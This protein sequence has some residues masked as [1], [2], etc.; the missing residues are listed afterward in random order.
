MKNKNLIIISISCVALL[1]EAC[2][3]ANNKNSKTESQNSSRSVTETNSSERI[4]NLEEIKIGTQTWAIENLDVSNF[5]NGDAISEAK[6]DEEW[7]KAGNEG[8][9]AWCYYDNDPANGKKYGK[10]YNWYAVNDARGLTPKDWHVPTDAEWTTLT[11]YLGGED[12]AGTKMKSTNGWNENGNG[13]NTSGFA[14]LPGGVRGS[15]GPFGLVGGVGNW[16]S[17]AESGADRVW[18]RF[19]FEDVGSVLRGYSFEWA[20]FSVRCLGD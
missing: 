13:T 12:V 15:L 5:R 8:N 19:L 10:L 3:N 7:K 17:F 1:L 6:T 4:N 2:R 9:P 18:C 20:G 11:D 16:W 14:G